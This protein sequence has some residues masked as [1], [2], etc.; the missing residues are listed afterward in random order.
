MFVKSTEIAYLNG[1]EYSDLI[2]ALN[3]A[4]ELLATVH[5]EELEQLAANAVDALATLVCCDNVQI[6]KME[7]EA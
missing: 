1:E 6:A 2:S 5:D 7:E 3:V 4:R